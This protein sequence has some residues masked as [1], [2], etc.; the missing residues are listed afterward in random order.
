M[1]RFAIGKRMLLGLALAATVGAPMAASARDGW[2]DN[3]RHGGWDRGGWH[4]D[5]DGW[6]GGRG[7]YY[8]HGGGHWSGGQWIAGAIVVGAVAGL[9]SQAV[10]PPPPP[11]TYYYPQ[12]PRVVYTQPG[13][14]YEDA[15]PAQP[16]YDPQ[17]AQPQYA[18]PQYVQPYGDDDG[19]Y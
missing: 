15:P 4:G 1:N 3:G 9:I 8:H 17:Y 13:V 6:R 11:P 7:D 5:R 16:A 10:A 12:Q 19:G 18:Q 14:V 2:H